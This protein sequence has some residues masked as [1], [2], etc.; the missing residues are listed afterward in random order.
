MEDSRSAATTSTPL[1]S[2]LIL[3]HLAEVKIDLNDSSQTIKLIELNKRFSKL[4][5]QLEFMIGSDSLLR[6]P[7]MGGREKSI[8][9][10]ETDIPR[11]FPGLKIFLPGNE[12]FEALQ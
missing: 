12:R 3:T 10:I 9:I 1:V 5:K 2:P 8:S 7:S 4:K 11:T 6:Q